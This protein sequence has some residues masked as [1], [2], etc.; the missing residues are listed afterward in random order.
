MIEF[1]DKITIDCNRDKVYSTLVFFFQNSSNYKQWHKDHISCH[2][3]KGKDFNSGSILIAKEYINGTAFTLAFKIIINKL[4]ISL[5]YKVLFPFSLICPGGSFQFI[6]NGTSTEF[7]AK[8]NFRFGSILPVLFK[9]H[10]DSLRL[11]IKEE[12]I[13]I[14]AIVEKSE[15]TKYHSA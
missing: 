2:W 6:E 12:G 4:D 10:L 8:L 3:K 9:R 1:V 11:H 13:S 15:N 7:I 5:D 14:K